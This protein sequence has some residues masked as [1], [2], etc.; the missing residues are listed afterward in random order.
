M[1]VQSADNLAALT[2]A[3][4]AISLVVLSDDSWAI[5][6]V[7]SK[8]VWMECKWASDLVYARVE[9]TAS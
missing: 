5:S 7:D 1:A 8:V 4:K 2:A 6:S 9:K 3:M